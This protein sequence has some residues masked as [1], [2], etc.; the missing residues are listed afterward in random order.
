MS[1]CVID[2]KTESKDI[3]NMMVQLQKHFDEVLLEQ[4][5]KYRLL[6]LRDK[7]NRANYDYIVWLSLRV[8]YGHVDERYHSQLTD[9]EVLEKV[10]SS[11]LDW[12]DVLKN[13]EKKQ[14]A[15]QLLLFESEAD[16]EFEKEPV[17]PGPEGNWNRYFKECEAVRKRNAMKKYSFFELLN[18]DYYIYSGIDYRTMLP[19]IEEVRELYKKAIII[20]K[21]DPGRHGWFWFDTP[22]YLTKDGGLSDIEL[23][24]RLHFIRLFLL[25]YKEYGSAWAD[26]SYTVHYRDE[27]TSYR[28][29]LDGSSLTT[30]GYHDRDKLELPSYEDVFDDDFLEWTRKTMKI[31]KKEVVADEEV[32]KCNIQVFF[33]RLLGHYSE[34]YDFKRAINSSKDWKCFKADIF[35]FCKEKGIDKNNGGG[36]GYSIDGFRAS[37]DLWRN[38]SIVI[39]QDAS[40]RDAINRNSEGLKLN[41][42]NKYVIYELSGDDIYK[43]AFELF[44]KKEV[45]KK[46]S[47]FDFAA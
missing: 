45:L 24:E 20:G 36:S 26:D 34:E 8:S 38:G 28:Y 39:E 42:Y 21:D 5:E 11:I 30:Y 2:R 29:Y 46:T 10:C 44:N 6:T 17:D 12:I 35:K 3:Q 37:C 9:D 41:E 33:I 25:P 14:N 1:C 16:G 4:K 32:L 40:I 22:S 19:S 27:H 47:L 23:R 15:R 18:V 13:F 43:K 31:D 7:T